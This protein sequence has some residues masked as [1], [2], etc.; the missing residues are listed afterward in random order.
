LFLLKTLEIKGFYLFI[1]YK[2]MLQDD[3]AMA[4]HLRHI[5]NRGGRSCARMVVPELLRPFMA[6]KAELRIPL[7]ADRRTALHELPRHIARFHD[8]FAQARC[9]AAESGAKVCVLNA[10]TLTPRQLAVRP[11]SAGHGALRE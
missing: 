2:M 10:Y 11:Q 7:G 5:L 6:G 9:H 4:G 1:C 3:A 8:L